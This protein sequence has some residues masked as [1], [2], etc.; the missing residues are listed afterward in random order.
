MRG[1]LCEE[2]M[3][4]REMRVGGEG[5]EGNAAI[6]T[7]KYPV[8]SVDHQRIFVNW[9]VRV[10]GNGVMVS[11]GGRGGAVCDGRGEGGRRS[12]GGIQISEVRRGGVGRDRAGKTVVLSYIRRCT[13]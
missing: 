13:M 4:A 6:K 2:D 10:G 11:V 5:G 7:D 9:V 1:G 8:A 3:A 12:V